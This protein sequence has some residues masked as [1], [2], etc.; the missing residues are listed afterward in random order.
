MQPAQHL[1]HVRAEYSPVGVAL[2]HDDVAQ[3]AEKPVPPR[4]PG[5]QRLMQHVRGGQQVIGVRAGPVPRRHGRVP[6]HHGR[7]D[8]G[9]GELTDHP[10]LVRGQGP[11][12]REVER[13]AALQDPGE[14]GQQ[15]PQR[16]PRGRRGGDNDVP[17]VPRVAGHRGLMGPGRG[18]AAPG[19]RVGDLGGHPSGPGC[20]LP[21]A[22]GDVLYV[23]QSSRPGA[24]AQHKVCGGGRRELGGAAWPGGIRGIRAW[25]LR[26]RSQVTGSRRTRPDRRLVGNERSERSHWLPV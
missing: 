4:M 18:H 1:G 11:G 15:I 23:D 24:V 10:E 25:C 9:Q 22:S 7:A 17:A 21:F 5:Q 14:R 6:V 12:R 26:G 13:G 16:L 2:I 3:A 8:P 19:E 20:R